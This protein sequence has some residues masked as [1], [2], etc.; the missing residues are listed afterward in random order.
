MKKYVVIM[1]VVGLIVVLSLIFVGAGLG[2]SL[3]GNNPESD[4]PVHM[5]HIPR[6]TDM[7]DLAN[8]HDIYYIEEDGIAVFQISWVMSE[9]KY[10]KQFL[11][12][13]KQISYINGI[14]IEN[15]MDYWSDVPV[16][17]THFGDPASVLYW[18]YP[19]LGPLTSG[20]SVTIEFSLEV[21][22][23]FSDGGTTFE[24]GSFLGP[25]SCTVV[26]E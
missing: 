8:P 26:W 5:I 21:V 23:K 2:A 16:E 9:D 24:P 6:C 22:N 1:G 7:D 11:P 3:F 14:E 19:P 15:D 12:N 18:T 4:V 25:F 13:I 17:W 20:K 10:S